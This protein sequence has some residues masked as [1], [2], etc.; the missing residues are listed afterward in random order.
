MIRGGKGK[1]GHFAFSSFLILINTMREEAKRRRYLWDTGNHCVITYH[2]LACFF[3]WARMSRV[4]SYVT[5]VCRILKQTWLYIVTR[6]RE[7]RSRGVFVCKINIR[8]R[9]PVFLPSPLFGLAVLRNP[10]ETNENQWDKSSVDFTHHHRHRRHRRWAK[11]SFHRDN[12]SIVLHAIVL[13]DCYYYYLFQLTWKSSECVIFHVFTLAFGF[14]SL[15]YFFT[16]PRDRDR[17][18]PWLKTE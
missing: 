17:F 3:I 13:F 12:L 7:I 6:A 15:F 10:R 9:K 1:D 8:T 11:S 4:A 5:S 18:R 14:L 2:V 16:R